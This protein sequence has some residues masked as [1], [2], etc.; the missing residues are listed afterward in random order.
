M[1][2]YFY[3]GSFYL[4]R[5]YCELLYSQGHLIFIKKARINAGFGM[6]NILII[7]GI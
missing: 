1:Q 3:Y 6:I 2:Q 5:L 4:N 7:R